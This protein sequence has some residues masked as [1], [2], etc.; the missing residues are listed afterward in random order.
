M[1]TAENNKRSVVVGVFV[2]LA[3]IILVAGIF[4]L[5]GK[6]KRFEKTLEVKAVFDNIAGLKAGNNVW[7]SG[8]KIGTVKSLQLYGTSQ[9][10]VTLK[11]EE[12]VQKYIHKDSKARLG[13]ES[14]IGNK[15]IEVYGGTPQ[16]P[17]VEEGDRLQIEQALSTDD[18][19]ETLQENNKNLLA[20]TT[21]FKK[22]SNDLTNGKGTV[23]AL[24]SDSTLANRFQSI[25]SNLQQVSATTSQASASL[26]QFTHKL[27]N[28]D[29]LVNQLLTDT[30]VFNQLKGSVNQLQT[31]AS[32]ASAISGNL[33]KASNNLNRNNNA[34]GMLLNDEQFATQLKGT[35]QNVETSTKKLDESMD[36]LRYSFFLKGAFKK[37]AKADAKQQAQ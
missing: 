14:L 16:A 36:A 26:S 23:G 3:I 4:I 25:V 6:Q 12:D 5:G 31:T 27:N 22:L 30:V 11:I 8:V 21:D 28:K 18:I 7:F 13:S 24:L 20:I 32:S 33:E 35:I 2:L 1:G 17:V 19:M 29:G 9:V 34:L 15:I 37:K 10:E